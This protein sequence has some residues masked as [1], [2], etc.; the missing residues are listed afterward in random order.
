MIIS[1]VGCRIINK[2]MEK[3]KEIVRIGLVI[4]VLTEKGIKKMFIN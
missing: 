3:T 1:K 2:K 4:Y